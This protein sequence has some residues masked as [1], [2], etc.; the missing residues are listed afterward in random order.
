[1]IHNDKKIAIIGMACRLPGQINSPE[2][3]WNTLSQG[4]DVVTEVTQKRWGTDFYCHPDKNE[5]GKTYTFSAG[6]LDNIDE[7][8]ANFF[9]ISPREADQMDP[10][11]RLLLELAWEAIEDSGITL[12]AINKTD[13]AVYV[14]IASNDYA[15]R[16]TD[17]L[18]SLDAYAMTGSTASVASNRISYAFDLHGPSVS[19][20][21]ACSSSLVAVHQ[22]CKTLWTGESPTALCG[23]I[24]MLIH[25]FP[26]I[27]FSKASMLSP[28]GRC[29]AFDDSGNGYVRSEG[30][31]M[32][33]LKPLHQAELDGDHIHAVISGSGIN[34]DGSTSGI[35]VPGMETQSA[36]LEKIYRDSGISAHDISYLEAHGT[37]TA[38]GDPLEATALGEVIGKQRA[39]EKPLL[40]GSAKTNLGHLETASGMAG[41][42]KAVLTLKHKVIPPSLHFKTPNK[43]IDFNELNLKVVTENT[44][45][46]IQEKPHFIGINSFGFGGANAH[47]LLEEYKEPQSKAASVCDEAL[48]PLMISAKSSTALQSLAKSYAE[49]LK[50]ASC[51]YDIAYAARFKRTSLPHGLAVTGQDLSDVTQG[52]ETFSETGSSDNCITGKHLDNANLAFVFTGN[53]CQWQGMGQALYQSNDDFKQAFDRVA[54]TLSELSTSYSLKEEL[55]RDET[56]SNLERTEI[57]QPLLFAIQT[58]IVNYLASYGIHPNAVLGHSVGEVAAAWAAGAL[59]L[60]QASLVI[61]HRSQAQGLT[62]G[63]GRMAAVGLAG[64]SLKTLLETLDTP[65]IIEVAG[66]NSPNSATVAGDLEA[67]E[68]LEIALNK[69]D[70]F[71][72][73]LDLDYAFHSRQMDSIEY[74]I[75]TSLA[76][77]NPSTESTDFI[78]TVTGKPLS[79]T[80]LDANYW[81]TNIRQPVQFN[82]AV[83]HLIQ[84]QVNVFVEIGPHAILRSYIND[85]MKSENISGLVLETLKRKQDSESCLRKSA[86]KILLS[87][88]EVDDKILFPSIGEHVNLPS[89][90]WQREY[91][92]YPL[93]P[94]GSNLV[95]RK[96]EH[97]LLGYRLK[98]SDIIW[99]NNLDTTEL[100]Y[101]ADHIVDDAIVL[102][103]A[104]YIEMALA[105]SFSWGKTETHHL[106]MVEIPTPI[107]LEPNKSKKVRFHL[108][109]SDGSFYISS[110]DRLSEDDWTQN[111]IGRLLG[112]SFKKEAVK[113]GPAEKDAN[114]HTLSAEHYALANKVGLKYGPYFQAV[115]SVTSSTTHANATLELPDGL[116]KGIEQYHLHPSLLDSGFQVLVD[117]CKSAINAGQHKALIPIQV[118]SLHLLQQH[119]NHIQTIQVEIIRQSPRSVVANFYLLDGDNK[120]IAELQR[121]RFRQVQFKSALPTTT[122][123]Y[124]FTADT[125]PLK[126]Q[127]P[128]TPHIKTA[129]L[130]SAAS[131]GISSNIDTNRQETH[132][133]EYILLIDMM[134]ASY[135]YKAITT[136]A[137]N[138]PFT[139]ESIQT[140]VIRSQHALLNRLILL[141]QE[142]ELL[143]VSEE[144]FELSID[145]ELPDA[146]SIWEYIIQESPDYL[147]ELLILSQCGEQLLPLLYGEVESEQLLRP[148]KSSL[149][150]QLFEVGPSYRAFNDGLLAAFSES[151]KSFSES[152]HCRILLITNQVEQLG[153]NLLHLLEKYSYELVVAGEDESKLG[154]LERSFDEYDSAS[155]LAIDFNNIDWDQFDRP[156]DLV[157]CTHVLHLFNHLEADL[158][159]LQYLLNRNG[160]LLALERSSDRFTDMTFGTNPDWW[161]EGTSRLLSLKEW[162]TA[163]IKSGF[164]ETSQLSNNAEQ[165]QGVFLLTAKNTPLEGTS[166]ETTTSYSL[167]ES[168]LII[169]PSGTEDV[170]QLVE[171]FKAQN[172]HCCILQH[173]KELTGNTD[174]YFD[175][176]DSASYSAVLDTES[177][178]RIVY[179]STA[180]SLVLPVDRLQKLLLALESV[181]PPSQLNIVT[182][183]SVTASNTNSLNLKPLASPLWGF[184]RVVMNEYPDLACRLIDIQCQPIADIAVKLGKELQFDDGNDEVILSANSRSVLRMKQ[185]NTTTRVISNAPAALDFKAPGSFKNLYWRPLQEQNLSPKEI[186]IQPIAAGLNFRDIMYAMGLLSD[187]AVEN[188]FAGPTL[189]MEVAGL[190]TRIGKD[191][192]EFNV[193]DEVLGFAPACFSNRVITDTTA[194]AHKP[195]AWSFE[196]A[197]TVPTAFFTVYY[198]FVQLAQ[199]QEGEKVLIHGASG[200][201][202][203][204]A[205]QLALHLGAEVFA[206]AGTPEKRAFAKNIG[207]HHV[208][209]SRSLSFENEIME[210]T[211]GDGVNVVLNSI[212][213]EAINRNLNILKPFG[214]F[215]ELGKRDF[216]ENSRI[217]LRPFRNNI[218]Y[219]GIDA[220]QLLIEKKALANHLFQD[221]MKLFETKQLHPLPHRVFEVNRI[222]D[223]FRYMQQSRQIGKIIV[224]IPKAL[225]VESLQ[226]NTKLVLDNQSNYIVSGGLS[227]FG[228]KTA[229][230]LADKGA[231]KLTLLGRKGLVQ[232][233]AIAAV[234]ALKNAGIEVYTPPCD[235]NDIKQLSNVLKELENTSS[236]IGGIIHAATLFDDALVRNLNTERLKTVLNAKAQGA[237]NFH[238]L[239]KHL[240]LDFFV[241]YS[242]ATTL[243]GNPGQ[244]N[245]VAANYMLENLVAYRR[246]QGLAASYAAWGAISDTGFL[247]RNQETQESLLS[248]LGGAALTSTQAL[249]ELE[250]LIVSKKAG[251]AY[252]NFDWKAI[253][254]TMPS[255]KSLKFTQQNNDLLHHGSDDADDFFTRIVN[256]SDDEVRELITN[257]LTQ[258]ISQILRLPIEKVDQKCSIYDLGMDSLM[259]MELLLAIEEQFNTK[260]PLMSLTEG[261]SIQKIA[262]K[263]HAKLSDT[264]IP[265]HDDT[266]ESLVSKHGTVMSDDE[267][268]RFKRISNE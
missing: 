55:F 56:K 139:F 223:A 142:N 12:D 217:G 129:Q 185:A 242:S 51:Y 198:A 195:S 235:V 200:G 266:I 125:L 214:R 94:E 182:S 99:E 26:F 35:T 245:Y 156:F 144:T 29:K 229:Q 130:I 168:W 64:D 72:R 33:L 115:T 190:V 15:H 30:A 191:V 194:T 251:A 238:Q 81:W 177:F 112:C 160:L 36:L 58:G 183:G 228:L 258:E 126:Q 134:V 222:Q 220:D 117:I 53:G 252:I 137:S 184:C 7:F 98:D 154:A 44:Q 88:C 248:R 28:D 84:Q 188:G 65:S 176:D 226:A 10:Q 205:I 171:E 216:Y 123:Q 1:M 179:L 169:D 181:T 50:R 170:E 61:H 4:K 86:L 227:G 2:D 215:L 38:V 85:C 77:L 178:S 104:A 239:T 16:R 141:L 128:E 162:N 114:E 250:S 175:A 234:E 19:V 101:L 39:S 90:P 253:K 3:Y 40:I 230:W 96:R 6:V 22:A 124:H 31:G 218:T 267:L 14:G 34:S 233:D 111:A 221:L 116:E 149:L 159:K 236:K 46:E 11:Q 186:E 241:L 225:P 173:E 21:T 231:K 255:A 204:A 8:D 66:E 192:T 254:R 45:L 264:A 108:D 240:P 135:A 49:Q 113:H 69:E 78:S 147:P 17:D 109:T 118:G 25:P 105:A 219:Y 259:G 97:P 249:N 265:D 75:L 257:I 41:L 145:E 42:I 203:I 155:T 172:I 197:A 120:L 143:R 152:Q 180:E 60:K 206:T 246:Q 224:R 211:E 71:Y 167:E 74:E 67:L 76:E 213:G 62:K 164:S 201:V 24:N 131:D 140:K 23:G 261:G 196:E 247:A 243:F 83:T 68:L 146:S 119:A 95:N 163:L 20:D 102:P 106:E 193:G 32:L 212:Y 208:M 52:L 150:E 158:K 91:H 237:W 263:I 121:C 138:K 262:E 133:N 122:N 187:E 37:G 148:E 202:G 13:C 92:W 100:P 107:L 79:G 199:L 210:I 157:L 166:S 207:A 59:S 232:D 209:D 151:L 165:A 9:G 136:L 27:G 244:A 110:R 189:G 87:G 48:P 260:L 127:W 132:F 43:N 161:S 82:D 256:L 73:L 153:S 47:V 268:D 80:E 57:A 54:E 93:T 5:P 70:K 174:L 103:A 18:A 63:K 89:Y